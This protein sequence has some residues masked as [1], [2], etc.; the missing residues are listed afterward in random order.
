MAD[1]I[2]WV[3]LA[4]TGA[5]AITS[6]IGAGAKG[7]ADSAMYG[8]QS[9]MALLRKQIDLQNADYERNVGEVQAQQSGEK[10]A[11]EIGQ[12]KAVQGA[13]NVDV[14]RGSAQLVRSTQLD[15]GQQNEGIIRSNAAH[16]AYG[17]DVQAA[18]DQAQSDIYGMAS[19]TAKT[20]GDIGVATSILGGAAS[21]SS[22]WLQGTSV[23]LFGA[24]KDGILT[25]GAALGLGPL[26][27][28]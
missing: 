15:I 20:A 10:T 9:G 19:Q 8:Y 16:R 6:A 22:K 17:Y 28:A 5:G 27:E 14:N 12:T 4:A 7:A 23:G 2:S 25:G 24:G 18:T 1:P 26:A 21:V 11:Q 13:G 3:G